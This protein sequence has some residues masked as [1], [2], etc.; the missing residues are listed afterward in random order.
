MSKKPASSR[1][2][3]TAAA[4]VEAVAADTQVEVAVETAAVQA[5]AVAVKTGV[6]VRAA[7]TEKF[8]FNVIK[9]PLSGP[10]GQQTPFYTMFR[11]DNGLQVGG[12]CKETF[13]PH[14]VDDVVVLAET[15]A[16]KFGGDVRVEA[17]WNGC[18]HE[19]LIAPRDEK[20]KGHVGDVKDVVWPRFHLRALYNGTAYQATLGLW[21]HSCSNLMMPKLVKGAS[22]KIYHS[23]NLRTRIGELNGEFQKLSATW[24]SQIASMTRMSELEI[25]LQEVVTKVFGVS[26]KP[27]GSPSQS[28]IRRYEAIMGRLFKDRVSLG[29]D[30][31][32]TRVTLWE[33]INAIQGYVQHDVT[34]KAY[35]DTDTVERAFI[36]IGDGRVE[37]AYEVAMSYLANAS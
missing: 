33:S 20:F 19:V 5:P 17:W 4:P 3:K 6:D 15:A 22:T 32:S 23:T 28:A 1:K 27:D 10:D 16:A 35:A 31:N 21:R 11:D 24:D 37:K 25:P 34:R 30:V 12:A 14:T 26:L 8:P 36:A 18:G 9:L 7:L 2:A 29:H 13:V